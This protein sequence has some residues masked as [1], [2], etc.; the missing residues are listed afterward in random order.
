LPAALLILRGQA[1][2]APRRFRKIVQNGR[3]HPS[4]VNGDK[5][6]NQ[7]GEC[8]NREH[9]GPPSVLSGFVD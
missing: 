9:F 6:V 5:A 1:D 8:G 4:A 2:V 3:G 7:M